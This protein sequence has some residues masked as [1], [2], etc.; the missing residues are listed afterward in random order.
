MPTTTAKRSVYYLQQIQTDP[1]L[2]KQR[3]VVLYMNIRSICY[4]KVCKTLNTIS[5]HC[6]NIKMR[7]T[8]IFIHGIKFWQV[9]CFSL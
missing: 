5:T 8:K 3:T 6:D 2:A 7:I 4:Q 9:S 1:H